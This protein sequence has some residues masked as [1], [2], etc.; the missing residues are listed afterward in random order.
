MLICIISFALIIFLCIY[1]K[2]KKV[3]KK[4]NETDQIF[5]IDQ[6]SQI[7]QNAKI[8]DTSTVEEDTD[9][10]DEIKSDEGEK[11]CQKC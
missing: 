9:H 2:R 5:Q 4:T 6:S 10:I 3:I 7:S 8:V 11:I 1:F